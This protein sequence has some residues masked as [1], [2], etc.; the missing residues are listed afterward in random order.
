MQD[1]LSNERLDCLPQV[2]IADAARKYTF[3]RTIRLVVR[4][5][6]RS[7]VVLG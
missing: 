2:T 1:Q 5:E 4:E 6:S 7:A 3:Q